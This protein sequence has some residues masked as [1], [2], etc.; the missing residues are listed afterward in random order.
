MI[1][2]VQ[3]S[4]VPT[5]SGL[6]F[7]IILEQAKFVTLRVEPWYLFARF[8]CILLLLVDFRS[9]TVEVACCTFWCWNCLRTSCTASLLIY[10]TCFVSR[11]LKKFCGLFSFFSL[12][13]LSLFF[14]LSFP[15]HLFST[16]RSGSCC[17]LS[18]RPTIA[19][20]T[21]GLEGTTRTKA[22]L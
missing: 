12:F 6:F 11:F 16:T 7:C 14:S 8:C 2:I 22:R 9:T 13:S 5:W 15:L 21:D 20:S 10:T 4:P 1:L 17:C 18:R 3:G 19:A